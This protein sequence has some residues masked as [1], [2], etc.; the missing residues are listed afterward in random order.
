M[1]DARITIK[2][3]QKNSLYVKWKTT[4]VTHASYDTVKESFKN[5]EREIL[6][7][8]QVAKHDNFNRI[9]TAYKTDIKKTWRSINETLR[10]NKKTCDLPSTFFHNDRTLSNTIEIANTFNLYFA[11]IGV[12]LVSEIETQLDN[13]IID[14]S[15]YMDTPASTQLKFKC[16]TETETLKDIDNLENKNSWGHDGISNKLLKLTKNILSN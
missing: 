10:R 16:I 7:Q 2:N 1:D 12:T 15:Q 8:I 13:N 4:P 6:K 11:N 9:F 14:F 5:C 3:C